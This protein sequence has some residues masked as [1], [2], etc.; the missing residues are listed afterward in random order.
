MIRGRSL[1]R[2][3]FDPL[4][5]T[6]PRAIVVENKPI[7]VTKYVSEDFTYPYYLTIGIIDRTHKKWK[8]RETKKYG[9]VLHEQFSS[10]KSAK[11]YG[12][13][14]FKPS[15]QIR[16]QLNPDEKCYLQSNYLVTFD[17]YE[18][19]DKFLT[20]GIRKNTKQLPDILKMIH[21]KITEY[22]KNSVE[23]KV[24]PTESVT[25]NTIDNTILPVETSHQTT[26]SLAPVSGVPST[27][28]ALPSTTDMPSV[29][30]APLG[31]MPP[32]QVPTLPFQMMTFPPNFNQ[33]CPI[34]QIAPGIFMIGPPRH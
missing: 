14:T 18:E 20:K 17:T 13:S 34:I 1:K 5:E 3:I 28:E 24:A 23:E 11:S 22:E 29:S 27:A 21:D 4:E 32:Y 33:M 10:L 31:W 16:V 9:F 19:I 7:K 12:H 6:A 15:F 8:P 2:K 25:H 26:N 30:N